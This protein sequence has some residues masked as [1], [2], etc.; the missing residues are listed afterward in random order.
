M[1]DS[2][3]QKKVEQNGRPGKALGGGT[4]CRPPLGQRV[5]RLHN[6]ASFLLALGAL[7]LVYRQLLDSLSDR[8]RRP[9]ELW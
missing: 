6:V 1:L 5:F 3:T 2:E 8:R 4:M 9:S 7:Y